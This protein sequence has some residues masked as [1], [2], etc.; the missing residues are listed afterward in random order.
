MRDYKHIEQPAA[1]ATEHERLET[2][3]SYVLKRSLDLLV[4][5]PLLLL[6]LPLMA[7]CAVAIRVAL[8][9]PVLFRQRRIGYKEVP[10]LLWKFRTMRDAKDASGALLADEDRLTALGRL[11]RKTSLDELPQLWNVVKGEMSLVGPRPLLPEYL[12]RYTAFQ[13]RRH[14]CP[15]GITG[16]AQIRGRNSLS[17]ERKFELDVWYVDHRSFW[18]DLRILAGTAAIVL[19]GAGT[20][21]AGHATMPQFMGSAE[22]PRSQFDS[23]R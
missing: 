10:F 16:W 8:R 2:L 12:P 19:R 21:Q 6:T 17:W 9:T 13:R 7:L 20:N 1:C 18:L 14:E 5:V 23:G 15:P 22:Q 4:S 3:G 11:L